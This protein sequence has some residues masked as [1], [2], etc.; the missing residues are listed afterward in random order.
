MYT[1]RVLIACFNKLRYIEL[2]KI[3][4]A[5]VYSGCTNNILNKIK[6]YKIE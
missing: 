1:M 2:R 6:M 3:I 5:Y 4:G